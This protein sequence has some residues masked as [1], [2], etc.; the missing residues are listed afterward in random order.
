M[1]KRLEEEISKYKVR[2]DKY[3]KIKEQIKLEQDLIRNKRGIKEQK[4]QA[5]N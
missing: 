3:E 2:I 1:K 4:E 5:A